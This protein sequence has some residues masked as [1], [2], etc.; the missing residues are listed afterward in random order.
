MK[1]VKSPRVCQNKVTAGIDSPL[2]FILVTI[3]AIPK[4]HGNNLETLFF[5]MF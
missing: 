2:V 5:D 1:L 3:L 4:R